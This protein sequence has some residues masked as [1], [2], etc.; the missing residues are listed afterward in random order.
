MNFAEYSIIVMTTLTSNAIILYT[1][2]KLE[3]F[4]KPSQITGREE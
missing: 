4:S 3:I 1:I 2:V